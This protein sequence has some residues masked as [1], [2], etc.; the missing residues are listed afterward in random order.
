M[1]EPVRSGPEL[2]REI[3]ET[4]VPP[5]G[6]AVWWLGQSG[7]L[8]KSRSGTAGWSIP[9]L[10]E[11]LTRKYESTDKPHVRMTDWRSVRPNDLPGVDL[12]PRQ[13][14]AFRPPRPRHAP[15]LA[16]GSP[17]RCWSCPRP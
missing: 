7:F 14:Q 16:G 11:H 2:L 9:Y 17:G 3:A 4:T 12:D 13:P 6:L 15:G 1:I 5:G 10:S 8:L